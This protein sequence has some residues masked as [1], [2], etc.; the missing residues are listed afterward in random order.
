MLTAFFVGCQTLTPSEN[1][2]FARE[3]IST[4]TALKSQTPS[5]QTC[6]GF[7]KL[8]EKDFPLSEFALLRGSAHCGEILPSKENF[9]WLKEEWTQVKLDIARKSD[10]PKEL[11]D[12]LMERSTQVP[13]HE[14]KVK[15]VLEAQKKALGLEEDVQ[16]KVETRLYALAPRMNKH[17]PPSQ[18]LTVAKD[19]LR[20]RDFENAREIY[21]KLLKAKK[22]SLPVQLKAFEGLARLEKISREREDSIQVLQMEQKYLHL[23]RKNKKYQGLILKETRNNEIELARALWTVGK[24]AQAEKLLKARVGARQKLF[25]YALHYWLL[26]RIEEEKK[27]TEESLKWLRLSIKEI[28]D[29]RVQESQARWFLAWNLYKR[30]DDQECIDTLKWFDSEDNDDFTKARALYWS[31]VSLNKLNQ[32]DAAKKTFEHLSKIDPLGYYGLLAKRELGQKLSKPAANQSPSDSYFFR[33]RLSGVLHS[34]WVDWM[35]RM[36][37]KDAL[38]RYLDGVSKDYLKSKSPA[39][40]IWLALLK[41]YA[42]AGEYLGLFQK[43]YEI[44]PKTRDKLLNDQPELLFPTPHLKEVLEAAARFH[45]PAELIYAII[46]QESAFNKEARSPA[47]AFGLM[48][49]LPKVAKRLGKEI[50]VPVD[51]YTDLFEPEKNILLGA[52]LVSGQQ[53]RHRHEF[54]STV[55]SYNASDAAIRGWK[56]SRGRPSPVEFIEEIPYEE[57]KSY[58]RLIIRNYAFYQLFLSPQKEI[59]FPEEVFSS[60]TTQEVH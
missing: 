32:P 15:L 52:Y 12:L 60:K 43:L 38:K 57:T 21:L 16:K 29:D 55:A 22:T 28:S 53:K 59:A 35:A 54:I 25:S 51:H 26:G 33:L 37:E 39:E 46:R 48:Q 13:L 24:R 30:G 42:R 19:F 9:P 40:D 58:V 3:W 10:T 34:E 49:L 36:G 11:V 18:S 20:A 47:D 1:S 14:D 5:P 31:A 23:H 7:K 6:E 56:E 8:A 27:N 2:P 44:P 17:S 45:V 4:Y 41:S 50:N